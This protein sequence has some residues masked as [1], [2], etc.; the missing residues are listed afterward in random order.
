MIKKFFMAVFVALFF[1]PFL[2][3]DDDVIF[4]IQDVVFDGLQNVKPKTVRS[5]IQLKK[6]KVYATSI[7][8]E[9]LRTI[10]GLGYF[11]NAEISVDRDKK[12]VKFTVVEKPYIKKIVFKG[13]K[14]FSEGKLKGEATL[15]EKDFYNFVELEESKRKILALYKDKG[16][17]DCQMEVYPTT[18]EDTNIMT[19]T[20]LI[21]ENNKVLI[22]DLFVEGVRSFKNKKIKKLAKT[23]KKKVFKEETL[24]NDMLSIKK[25][26]V[27]RGFMDFSIGEPEITYDESRTKIFVTLRVNEGVRYK[28]GD[29][30]FEGN[31]V[32][33]SKDLL[34]HSTIKRNDIFSQEKVL[35]LLNKV[36]DDYSNRGYLH[37]YIE[38][39]F[40]KS[41]D[42]LMQEQISTKKS[43][44]EKLIES[45][46]D[47]IDQQIDTKIN[48]TLVDKKI[49]KLNKK[50]ERT[51]YKT[52][53]RENEVLN[54]TSKEQA[55][56]DKISDIE[57]NLEYK[58]Y[59][60]EDQVAK[61]EKK[62]E[63]L[64]KK[65][66]KAHKELE[67]RQRKVTQQ[68]E[69][70]YLIQSDIDEINQKVENRSDYLLTEQQAKKLEKE[71]VKLEK[72]LAK[73]QKNKEKFALKEEKKIKKQE[74]KLEKQSV[75]EEKIE[76]KLN[77]VK[78]QL[79]DYEQN[80][81]KGKQ[82]D[83]KFDDK[84]IK[85]LQKK[86]TKLENKIAKLQ[87]KKVIDN[88]VN[89]DFNI[90]ENNIVYVGD[91]YVDGLT[92]TKDNTIRRE[93]LL[94]PGDVFSSGKVRRS[95]EKIYNLGFIDGAEPNIAPTGQPD[96]MN[97]AFS[98]T[99]GKPG[100][101]TAGAGY[102]SVDKFVGSIQL[103]HMNLFGRAQKLN[104]LWEFGARRQNY[105]IDWTEP[106]FLGKAM[107]LGLSLYN[108]E[109][110]RDYHNTSDAYREGRL[111]GSVSI[112]P[113]IADKIAL[114]FGYTY[115]HVR[116]FNIDDDELKEEI[117]NDPDLAKD[118]TSSVRAQIVYDTRDYI[119]DATR[120][121]RY[122][123][124]ITVAGGPFGGNVNYVRNSVRGTWFFPTFWK[125]VLSININAGWIES[126]G[127]S[128]EVPL[129]EKY[130]VGGADTIRGY[131]YRTEIGPYNGGKV[132]AVANVEYKFPIVQEN[133]KTI[134]QGAFF[135]DIGGTWRDVNHI[136]FSFGTD[137]D[138]TNSYYLKSG[139]GF[140]IRFATPVF[141]LRLDWGYGLNHK[142]G[143]D[144]QQF[145]FT[146]GNV[147]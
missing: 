32:I 54:Q 105:E 112:S 140:G 81:I 131:K 4:R 116:I 126:Y 9:D 114:L 103:Q 67:K 55:I 11:D 69:K 98:I 96:I 120:G 83:G 117:L 61:L 128:S 70:E 102:S 59:K 101:I 30:G 118:R 26:Y 85:K 94:R 91:I 146:I 89:V 76:S 46:I 3:A 111:G 127:S 10:L 86:K 40:S 16:Y 106:W 122:S 65:L 38:P 147:F 51:K 88:V 5:E 124:G 134:L 34:K 31:S 130:Y 44:K 108:I 6:G 47:S 104:L 132:M 35:E 78:E 136:N 49:K 109:R 92:K 121:V 135:Y 56:K 68:K 93:I 79:K 115:E 52:R 37:S 1:V 8:R 12:T 53:N 99:E 29:V 14:Q 73:E 19:I 43:E 45:D 97:L 110:L 66:T 28:M 23:K 63:K 42:N 142:R 57:Q 13:N 138:E 87:T 58:A 90:K 139:V 17:A 36:Y 2:F 21:T 64:E 82:V 125:F 143:E 129:Y 7:A 50:L 24:K 77:E 133:K 113:R 33:S 107:S 62:K 18:D 27:N 123:Y 74:K 137:N 119:Y 25:F 95:M 15:K 22:G 84:Q 41:T 48:K 145:Y 20:F 60:E 39:D 71:K 100:M 144:L 141:P 72:D 75:K 80:Y